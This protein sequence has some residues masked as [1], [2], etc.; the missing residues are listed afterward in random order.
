[1]LMIQQLGIAATQ[2]YNFPQMNVRTPLPTRFVELSIHSLKHVNDPDFQIN[3]H[4]FQYRWEL[5]QWMLL[6]PRGFQSLPLVP[7]AEET[8]VTAV[9]TSWVKI[10]ET[11]AGTLVA[12]R[13]AN[14]WREAKRF[15]YLRFGPL[16]F[17]ISDENKESLLSS[18]QKA[19]SVGPQ[20]HE[21]RGPSSLWQIMMRLTCTFERSLQFMLC[22]NMSNS[23]I[24]F[25]GSLTSSMT[26]GPMQSLKE[27]LSIARKGHNVVLALSKATAIRLN[28]R[29]IT[30]AFTED[31]IPCLFKVNGLEP[32]R[33][34]EF[35]GH[36]YVARLTRGGYSF[37]LDIDKEVAVTEGIEAVERLL[38]NDLLSQNYP[39]TLRLAHIL[40]TFTANEILGMQRYV[41][42][43]YNLEIF[44]RPDIHRLLFGPYGKGEY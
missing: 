26:D 34:L 23:V 10:G 18:L 24:L 33:P 9:D 43:R 39:E 5:Q 30:E 44:T 19:H 3:Q 20:T 41:A 13:G 35:L 22:E 17:H 28:G 36:V 15:R 11:S 27:V 4:L 21:R 38:G 31:R 29:L 12:I 25:D 7:K 32:I 2:R 6:G 40:C 42:H 16:I 14:V 37:R 8:V 1:M